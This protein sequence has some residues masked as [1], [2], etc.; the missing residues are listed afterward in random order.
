MLPQQAGVSGP[1]A[2][3][4]QMTFGIP[5]GNEGP[6]LKSPAG[7]AAPSACCLVSLEV[8]EIT[9]RQG[10]RAADGNFS[11]ACQLLLS[12]MFVQWLFLGE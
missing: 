1:F 3:C 4:L 11:T 5:A 7:G 9:L 10:Q 12:L 2:G 6:F 8:N